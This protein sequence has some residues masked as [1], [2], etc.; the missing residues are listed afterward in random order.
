M[1][2]LLPSYAS[3]FG[4]NGN[5]DKAAFKAYLQKYCDV[6]LSNVSGTKWLS[7]DTYP[8]MANK[9][10]LKNFLYDIGTLKTVALENGAHAHVILQSYGFVESG[11]SDKE[12][13]PSEAE[14]RMQAYTAMAFGVDSMSWYVYSPNGHGESDTVANVDGT[15]RDQENYDA[16]KNINAELTAIGKVYNAFNWKGIILGAGKNNGASIGSWE[17]TKDNDYKAFEMVMGQLGEYELS[18][19]DT[20]YLASVKT[21]KTDWNYLLGVMEDKDV[22]DMLSCLVPLAQEFITVRPDSPRA[23]EAGALAQM[24]AARFDVPAVAAETVEKGVALAKELAGEGSAVA[25]LGSLYFAG[26]I[27]CAMGK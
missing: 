20:K 9:T 14:L 16:F 27:R 12:R 18:A 13:M 15:I 11:N 23:M 17:I 6:V 8:I 4:E 1:G 7:I 24:L 21:N 5:P 19:S 26:E 25:A 3:I 22:A 2:N 10:L